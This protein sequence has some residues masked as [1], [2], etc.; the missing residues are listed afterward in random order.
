VVGAEG[1]G[2]GLDDAGGE[3]ESVLGGPTVAASPVVSAEFEEL[4][5]GREFDIS[6]RHKCG[7]SRRLTYSCALCA[8]TPSKPAWQHVMDGGAINGSKLGTD[9][10]G[11][12]ARCRGPVQTHRYWFR[13]PILNNDLQ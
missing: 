6:D 12:R 5:D 13:Y 3:M 8:S 1:G 2:D 9:D 10:R 7:S 4:I 11:S